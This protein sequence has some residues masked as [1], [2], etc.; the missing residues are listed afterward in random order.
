MVEINKKTGEITHEFRTYSYREIEDLY[1]DY[2]DEV[3]PDQT[4]FGCPVSARDYKDS[5]D[6][7][8]FRCGCSDYSSEYYTEIDSEY[9]HLDDHSAIT[10]YVDTAID[11]ISDLL[12]SLEAIALD[13]SLEDEEELEVSVKERMEELGVVVDKLNEF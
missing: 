5:I 2:L 12:C 8:A 3:Y 9:I 7:V 1:E 10:S 6:P 4:A 13:L 11:E